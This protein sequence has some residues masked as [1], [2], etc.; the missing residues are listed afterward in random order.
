M[1]REFWLRQP[2][3][4]AAVVCFALGI[5]VAGGGFVS[6]WSQPQPVGFTSG[7][8]EPSDLFADVV[9]LDAPVESLET[10]EPAELVVY[11]SGAVLR[12]D[13]YRL[14]AEARI[15]D[16]VMAAGGF[17]PD[18]ATEA[19][20]LAQPILDA[21]HIHVPYQ[22]DGQ[23]SS[24]DP[25]ETTHMA[26]GTQLIDL[27]RATSAELETLPGVGPVLAQRIVVRRTE[28]GAYTSVE[29]LRDVA[30][31]GDKLFAQIEPLIT[32]AR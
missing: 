3:L 25:G 15:K 19:I 12:P 24:A 23:A 31:I 27:N 1:D 11:I 9:P 6:Q 22:H 2:R 5:I 16:V 32:V 7:L 10:A 20:N 18:A 17:T 14:P 26:E 13:V 28:Q 30:G 21:D 4:I 8:S 29:Q